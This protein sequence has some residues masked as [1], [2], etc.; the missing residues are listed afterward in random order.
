MS[1]KPTIRLLLQQAGMA[2]SLSQSTLSWMDTHPLFKWL[3][4]S[5]DVRNFITAEEAKAYDDL[6]A[7]G[8]DQLTTCQRPC[9]RLCQMSVLDEHKIDSFALLLV[10]WLIRSPQED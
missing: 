6:A 10:C 1:G 5:V 3:A 4:D 9:L 2:D 8:Q 7:S